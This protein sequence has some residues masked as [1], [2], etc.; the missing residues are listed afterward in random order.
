MNGMVINECCFFAYFTPFL[1]S[2][3]F[4]VPEVT[5]KKLRSFVVNYAETIFS[6]AGLEG[7]L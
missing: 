6:L 1:K 5:M 7:D 2:V 3:S 4:S